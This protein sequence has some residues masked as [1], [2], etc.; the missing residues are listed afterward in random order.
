MGSNWKE[1]DKE[2]SE[3][4][5]VQQNPTDKS[6]LYLQNT[7]KMLLVLSCCCAQAHF[8]NVCV[9]RVRKGTQD[10]LD[11]LHLMAQRQELSRNTYTCEVIYIYPQHTLSVLGL[12]LQLVLPVLHSVCAYTDYICCS[13][14]VQCAVLHT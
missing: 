9:L 4:H 2:A 11:H 14:C 10:C 3:G 13:P 8:Y 1:C 5:D 6:D 7:F 12:L